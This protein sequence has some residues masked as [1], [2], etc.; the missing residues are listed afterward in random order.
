VIRGIRRDFC[1]SFPPK[2]NPKERE[3]EKYVPKQ[4]SLTESST[5]TTHVVE[6]VIFVSRK[7][8]DK[9]KRGACTY[10]QKKEKKGKRRSQYLNRRVVWYRLLAGCLLACLH[11]RAVSDSSALVY[12]MQNFDGNT[13]G[14]FDEK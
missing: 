11:S 7:T 1:E 9:G 8:F 2:S 6:G 10:I 14:S 12:K 4:A 13:K 3:K 5:F